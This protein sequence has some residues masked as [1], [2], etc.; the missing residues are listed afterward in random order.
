MVGRL[1]T[2]ALRSKNKIYSLHEPLVD[3]ISKGKA[4]KRY[5]FGC[6]VSIPITAQKAF[7]VDAKSYNG[8][9]YDGHT[10]GDQLNQVFALTSIQPSVCYVDLGYRGHGVEN[11]RVVIAGQKRGLTR[12]NMR[13]LKLSNSVE[14]IN[15]HLKAEGKLGRC[16]LKGTQGDALN[17][18]LS[19]CGQN[20]RRLVRRLYVDARKVLKTLFVQLIIELTA[21]MTALLR[22][23]R[24]GADV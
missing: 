7:I 8:T 3:R 11:T 10:L 19:A 5:E 17:A 22:E 1:P 13:L 23:H 6:K 9:P 16:Y 2:Q 24:L 4:H 20:L 12:L 14:P 21:E 15:R 18:L